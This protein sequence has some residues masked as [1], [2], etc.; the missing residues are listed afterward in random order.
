MQTWMGLLALVLM[1]TSPAMAA[2]ENSLD[3]P[4]PEAAPSMNDYLVPPPIEA[5]GIRQGD[6]LSEVNE[7]ENAP[8]EMISVG[9]DGLPNDIN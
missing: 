8:P 9:P 7:L 3:A 6:N 4:Q 1:I 2:E 5:E